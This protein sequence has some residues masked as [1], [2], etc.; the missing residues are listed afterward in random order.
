MALG[1]INH[2]CLTVK[3]GKQAYEFYSPVLEYLGYKPVFFKGFWRRP[4]PEIGDFALFEARP[5]FSDRNHERRAPGLHHLAFNADSREQVDGLYE[6]LVKIGAKILDPPQEV[7][8]SSYYA[9]YFE[10][11]DGVKLELAYTP[12]GTYSYAMEHQKGERWKEKGRYAAPV[13]PDGT[14]G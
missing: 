10:D 4:D 1:H 6:V 2:I 5:E 8:G 14:V 9:V 3:D 13:L 12:N 11:P 7:Y